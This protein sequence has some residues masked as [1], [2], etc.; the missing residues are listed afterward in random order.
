M[1][2]SRHHLCRR[3][4]ACIFGAGPLITGLIFPNNGVRA[5]QARPPVPG[6]SAGVTAFVDV[7]VVP[8]DTERVLTRQTV[9]VDGGWITALGPA[10][11]VAVP[12]TATRIDGRDKYLIPG[13]T[14]CHAHLGFSSPDSVV[15]EQS[16]FLYVANGITTVR[17]MDHHR[18]TFPKGPWMRA[19]AAEG[20]ILSPRFYVGGSG[21]WPHHTG[22]NKPS[23]L[24]TVRLDGVA[25]AVAAFKATGYDF[26]KIYGERGS[27]YDSV[28]AAAR[29]VGIPLMGHV[30]V[31]GAGEL[32]QAL[33]AGQA[34]I[35]HLTGYTEALFKGPL[36]PS[37]SDGDRQLRILPE[38]L[39][40]QRRLIDFGKIPQ[41]AAATARAGVWNCP[42]Q[43]V[44]EKQ[45]V[46]LSADTVS[47]WPELD[48]VAPAER[49][50]WLAQHRNHKKAGQ[51][52]NT[53]Y[54]GLPLS[55]A[56]GH[57]EARRGL[58]KALQD[59]GAGL[60]L[61][62]DV[63][64]DGIAIHRELDALVRAGLTPYQALATGTRNS[65]IF[66]QTF[67]KK[68]AETGTVAVGK[69]ADLV[70][71][72]GNPLENIRYTA[73]RAGV[74][75]GGRWLSREDI[76]RRLATMWAAGWTFPD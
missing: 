75:L 57:L 44:F 54:I 21:Q 11:Q 49:E 31:R 12:A 28:S 46:E 67:L 15:P 3:R 71:L 16:L 10:S 8:M 27:A 36:P 51:G 32:E 63:K 24:D 66:F 48:F 13:L 2:T 69:R 33:Q 40:A 14:E 64:S 45:S 37:S 42:T 25:S 34:S 38:S 73:Q 53:G 68:P 35:E 19:M 23:V 18:T 60:L 47:W 39:A 58:V 1:V 61:G 5:Q 7:N 6:V 56:N 43:W 4:Y 20:K 41:L 50:K 74:M 22:Q 55:E 59:A 52:W 72:N 62:T 76:D 29:R 65:A 30:A 26:I 17:N 9:L 70:L